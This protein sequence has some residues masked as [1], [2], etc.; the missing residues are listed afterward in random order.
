MNSPTAADDRRALVEPDLA[1]AFVEF[2]GRF[3]VDLNDKS[4]QYSFALLACAF[5]EG[6][7]YNFRNPDTDT[8]AS[9]QEAGE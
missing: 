3:H 9:K 2:A 6:A 1:D 5:S 7:L 4:K 8:T